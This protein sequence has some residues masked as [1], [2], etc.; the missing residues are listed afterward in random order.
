MRGGVLHRPG[1]PLVLPNAWDA[2]SAC[3]VAA[4]RGHPRRLLDAVRAGGDPFFADRPA[5]SG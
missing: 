5:A 1:D 3:Q 4:A 2:G